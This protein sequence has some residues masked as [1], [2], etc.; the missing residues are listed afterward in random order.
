MD[1]FFISPFEDT[2]RLKKGAKSMEQK[3][4]EWAGTLSKKFQST[5]LE[6]VKSVNGSMLSFFSELGREVSESPFK[7]KNYISFYEELSSELIDKTS[8]PL[9]FSAENI[10]YMESF[11]KLTIEIYKW[12]LGKRKISLDNAEECIAVSA[13]LFSKI[14]IIT[15]EHHQ[16]IIDRFFSDPEKAWLYINQTIEKGW[17][18]KALFD[19]IQEEFTKNSTSN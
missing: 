10:M 18:I 5:Q 8:K 16:I 7:D 9:L 14:S 4:N 3:F 1:G 6:T 2:K 12:L 15:W 11:Y 13:E 17:G 19:A